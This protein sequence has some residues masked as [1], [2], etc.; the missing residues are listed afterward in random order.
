MTRK[1]LIAVAIVL[2]IAG[3]LV[4]IKALQVNKLTEFG[5]AYAPP[6]ESVSPVVVREESWQSTLSAIGSIVAIQGVTITP[7]LTG[8]VSSIAFESGASVSQ[9]DLLVKLDT[10][11]EEALLRAIEAQLDLAR[12]NLSREQKLRE[13]NMV[14]QSELDSAEATMKQT[15]ANAD[16]ERALIAKKTIRAP[17]TGQAGIRQINLGQYV[18]AGKPIV[19]LQTVNPVYADFTLPQQ[20]L[21]LLTNG[22]PVRLQ[23]D[24][25]PD[26]SFDG[27]LTAINPGLDQS[28]RSVGLRATFNNPDQLLRPGMF[29]RVQVLLPEQKKVL[30]IPSTSVL[31]A[32]SGDSVFIIESGSTNDTLK[33]RQQLVRLGADR[34]DFVSILSGVKPGDR[35]VGSGLFKLRTG[36]SVVEQNSI[37]PKSAEAPKPSDS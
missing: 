10:S 3:G 11:S 26:R 5:K 28:T 23:I 20:N 12:I 35:I 24:A 16:A 9:G 8:T 17:F 25:Y 37:T 19:W 27:T 22:M 13:Q 2:V 18:D 29:A 15:Q 31:R 32:P 4:G 36:M 34:G 6:P 33:V 1:I 14:S 30:V 7:E 21:A